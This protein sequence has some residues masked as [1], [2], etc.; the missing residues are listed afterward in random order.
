MICTLKMFSLLLCGAVLGAIASAAGTWAITSGW[1]RNELLMLARRKRNSARH[2]QGTR[3][4]LL[5]F[6]TDSTLADQYARHNGYRQDEWRLI[7]SPFELSGLDVTRHDAVTLGEFE[8]GSPVAQAWA[9]YMQ[10]SAGV[11]S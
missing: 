8:P 3:K 1:Y 5:V 10:I 9:F 6:S 4:P 7:T 2:T 11:R